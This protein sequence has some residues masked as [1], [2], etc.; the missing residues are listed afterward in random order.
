MTGLLSR[1]KAPGRLSP[2][3]ACDP[4]AIPLLGLKSRSYL[5]GAIGVSFGLIICLEQIAD[6]ELDEAKTRFQDRQSYFT[7]LPNRDLALRL[8][9]AIRRIRAQTL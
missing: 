5:A 3:S 2:K 8:S 7:V 9:E 4:P 6:E 1:Q